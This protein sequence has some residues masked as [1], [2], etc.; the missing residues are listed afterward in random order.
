[1]L[2]HE[3]RNPLGVIRT[4]VRLLRFDGPSDP[5]LQDYRSTLELQAE[6]M[7]RL[8]DDLL[9]VPRITRGLIRL[10]KEPCDLALIARQAIESHRPLAAEANLVIVAQLPDEIFCVTGDQA[11]LAQIVGNLLYNAI[12]FTEG[13]GQINVQLTQEPRGKTAL[14]T[15]RDTGIG[16]EN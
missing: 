13:G 12:K 15:V 6:Q 3:L 9:D 4:V 1:M 2:G 8:L 10:N 16:T 5:R 11:R 14:L 7:T